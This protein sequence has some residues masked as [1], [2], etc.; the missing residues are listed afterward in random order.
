MYDD[1]NSL[2]KAPKRIGLLE[3]PIKSLES[4]DLEF[5]PWIGLGPGLD[6]LDLG[7]CAH[8]T[9]NVDSLGFR[10][11]RGFRLTGAK[12]PKAPKLL[13]VDPS[14]QSSCQS[15]SL[16]CHVFLFLYSSPF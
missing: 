8:A 10:G 2:Q 12:H 4:L 13:L 14:C 1:D 6:G 7:T 15:S 11:F 9:K 5:E 3:I 16:S